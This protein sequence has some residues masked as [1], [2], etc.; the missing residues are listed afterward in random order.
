MI[1]TNEGRAK[2]LTVVAC[3]TCTTTEGPVRAYRHRQFTIFMC[4]RCALD[5]IV[6]AEG[7]E[8]RIVAVAMEAL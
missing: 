7:R 6:N 3:Q 4:D 5:P 2:A 1:A 8:Y